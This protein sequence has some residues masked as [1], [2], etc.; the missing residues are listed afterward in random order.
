MEK[1]EIVLTP[2]QYSEYESLMVQAKL[3]ADQAAREWQM[4]REAVDRALAIVHSK[5]GSE[6]T[7][8]DNYRSVL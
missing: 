6:G 8:V 5:K 3:K 4:S 2:S 1:K 7:P